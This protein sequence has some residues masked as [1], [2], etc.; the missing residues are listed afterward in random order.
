M[1]PRQWLVLELQQQLS[2]QVEA[3]QGVSNFE[4]EN[5]HIRLCDPGLTANW[6]VKRIINLY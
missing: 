2:M 1:T 6:M 5:I 3:L 4:S